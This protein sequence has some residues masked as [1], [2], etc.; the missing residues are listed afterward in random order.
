MSIQKSM[1]EC[2]SKLKDFVDPIIYGEMIDRLINFNSDMISIMKIWPDVW[3]QLQ[4]YNINGNGLNRKNVHFAT[5]EFVLNTR[6]V[7]KICENCK[8]APTTI[9]E[10]F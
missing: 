2:V 5:D 1:L 8:K 3:C 7:T 9:C 10:Y 4:E 6:I